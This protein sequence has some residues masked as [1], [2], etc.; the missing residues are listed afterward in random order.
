L[1]AQDR[2]Y[3]A[4][5]VDKQFQSARKSDGRAMEER[6]KSAILSKMEDLT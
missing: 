4:Q 5:F 6:W 1:K 2:A 3:D